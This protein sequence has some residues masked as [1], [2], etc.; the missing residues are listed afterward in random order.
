MS[1]ES[2]NEEWL[3]RIRAGDPQATQELWDR[4][5]TQLLALARNRLTRSS[6]AM[7]DEEDVVLSA[8]K[9]FCIGLRNGRFPELTTQESLWRLLLTITIRKISDK[10][11]YEKRG[12]R[13]VSKQVS[14]SQGEWDW[15]GEIEVFISR[16]PDP[17]L[18]TECTEQ[19]GILLDSLEQESLRDV[20]VLKMEGYTNAEIA[21]LR[22]CSLSSVERKLRSI[23]S[24][25]NQT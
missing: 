20:A 1:D 19:I 4:F 10:K 9:S 17:I 2:A 12:K 7:S 15:D 25:W 18:M 22:S 11:A 23:R 24:I 16:E 21:E 6:R 3:S 14:M 13:D 8:I 5:F